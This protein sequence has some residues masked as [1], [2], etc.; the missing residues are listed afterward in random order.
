MK[1]LGVAFLNSNRQEGRLASKVRPVEAKISF[2]YS[3]YL[4][5]FM[6]L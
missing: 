6:K 2:Y 4:S 3:M 1:F 5:T